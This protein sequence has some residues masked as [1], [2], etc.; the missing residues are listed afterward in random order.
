METILYWICQSGFSLARASNKNPIVATITV[1][2][3]YLAFNLLEATVEKLIF[4]HR[5]EHW[6]D[7]IFMLGFIGYAGLAVSCC[8]TLRER[9]GA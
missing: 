3:F 5:F 8:A 1:M 7:P 4:G 6:L 2:L 9:E